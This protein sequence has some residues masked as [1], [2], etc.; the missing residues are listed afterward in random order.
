M[1]KIISVALLSACMLC[2]VETISAQNPSE[3]HAIA[4]AKSQCGNEYHGQ[5]V[6]WIAT[7]IIYGL[8]AAPSNHEFVVYEVRVNLG[9]PLA[10]QPNGPLCF[11]G[12]PFPIAHVTYDCEG[13]VTVDCMN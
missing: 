6:E 11:P 13:K 2:S 12:L 7:P 4:K 3:G 10:N 9:C 8:C 5:N 1:K